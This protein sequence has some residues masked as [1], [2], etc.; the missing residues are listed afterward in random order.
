MDVAVSQSAVLLPSAQGA[1]D[2][3]FLFFSGSRCF[4]LFVRPS[5]QMIR[6]S[7]E[8]E[9]AERVAKNPSWGEPSRHLLLLQVKI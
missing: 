3:L 2:L 7:L 5:M 1:D 4:S 9:N 6:R 8:A